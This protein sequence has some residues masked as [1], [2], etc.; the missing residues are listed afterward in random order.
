M[1]RRPGNSLTERR[2]GIHAA[3]PV[4]R[5]HAVVAVVVIALAG[6]AGYY[7]LQDWIAGLRAAD[8]DEARRA[9]GRGLVGGA[10]VVC[11]PVLVLAAQLWR[12]GSR[13]TQ[14]ARFPLPAARLVRDTPILTGEAARIR[15]R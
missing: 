5:R 8:P 7:L 4:A 6:V 11:L 9:L 15:G 14:A 2:A 12:T 13:V 3:D 10:W 1:A